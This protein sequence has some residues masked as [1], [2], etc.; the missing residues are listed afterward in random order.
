MQHL[1]DQ[2]M[3]TVTVFCSIEPQ[4]FGVYHE[5]SWKTEEPFFRYKISFENNIPANELF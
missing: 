1:T 4:I 2:E 5:K 3:F